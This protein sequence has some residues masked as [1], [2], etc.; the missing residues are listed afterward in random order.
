MWPLEAKAIPQSTVD[1]KAA[2]HSWLESSREADGGYD[3]VGTYHPPI[4]SEPCRMLLGIESLN[5]DVSKVV[6][7]EISCQGGLGAE[8][9]SSAAKYLVDSTFDNLI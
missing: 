3:A 8:D 5:P 1:A 6:T 2:D 7:Q 4:T 9:V